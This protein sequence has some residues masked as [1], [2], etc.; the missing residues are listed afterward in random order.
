M[1]DGLNLGLTN[2]DVAGHGV[3]PLISVVIPA[4]N[5]AASLAR[6]AQS[7]LGQRDERTELLI[8][9]DGSTDAT[10]EVINA[11]H[12]AY[13]E[14]FRSI[15]KDNGGLASV[16]NLGISESGGDWLVFLDADDEFVQG[17]LAKLLEHIQ[18]NPHS[19]LV[20]GEHISVSEEGHRRRHR[21]NSIPENAFNRVKAYLLDKTFGL[22][23]GACAM[24][25]EV[26]EQGGYPE[27]FR[28]SED[29][30]VFAQALA[31]YP[32]ST[33]AEPLLLL[34]KH[35]DSLRHHVG[36][37]QAVGTQVVDEVFSRLPAEMQ[38]L[39]DDFYAQ[40]CLSLFRSAYLARDREAAK[41]YY[42]AALR[43]DW[44]LLLKTSYTRK[45]LRLWLAIR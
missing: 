25:R 17:A 39:R 38:S 16:R 30:S 7:I 3:K 27:H 36:H 31:R 40:R 23:N 4:Y 41:K 12:L 28:N 2:N 9:D 10:P 43:H 6:A 15:R 32:I 42:S 21:N 11:L 19:C 24:R 33:L 8:I 1:L 37:G 44:R 29:L 22:S 34:Y 20:I 5:Y 35:G 26:F 14:Q 45:A 13:P 18:S